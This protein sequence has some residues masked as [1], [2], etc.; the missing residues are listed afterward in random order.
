MSAHSLDDQA[1]IA[2]HSCWT[3]SPASVS[4]ELPNV[5]QRALCDRNPSV[6]ISALPLV[7]DLASCD[8]IRH[9]DLVP[10]LVAILKQV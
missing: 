6:M 9:R 5:V 2:F 10:A 4:E 3:A 7:E 8:P 1:I